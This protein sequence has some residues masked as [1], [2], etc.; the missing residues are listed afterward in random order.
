MMLEL[1]RKYFPNGTNGTLLL[2]GA[3]ICSTIEQ[4][5]KN[6]HSQISCIPEGKYKII[7]R[8]SPHF[9]RDLQVRDVPGRQ[10]ILIH[11]AHV[12]LMELKGCIAP[13]SVLTGIGKG[14][15]SSVAFQKITSLLFR[16]LEKGD[17]FLTIK[18]N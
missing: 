11:P 6:N 13:V 5:W 10:L 1:I 18:S 12:A 9:Q 17:I 7:K 15:F 8:F 4:P 2:E 14:N 3:A 16:V